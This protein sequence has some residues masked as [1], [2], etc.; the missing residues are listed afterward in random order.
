MF[1]WLQNWRK[2]AA[3]KEQE[4]ITVYLDGGMSGREAT[5]FESRLRADAALQAEIEAQ[6]TVKML[7]ARAPKLRAPRNFVLDPAVYGRQK[8]VPLSW[9]AMIYPQLRTATL[10]ASLLFAVTL[11]LTLFNGNGDRVQMSQDVAMAPEAPAMTAEAPLAE[12]E[13]ALEQSQDSESIATFAIEAES[14]AVILEEESAADE[15]ASP[16]L[17]AEYSAPAA[18]SS[19]DMAVTNGA[20]D[21]SEDVAEGEAEL[22]APRATAE[23]SSRVLDNATSET[24]MTAIPLATMTKAAPETAAQSQEAVAIAPEDQSATKEGEELVDQNAGVGQKISGWLSALF[25]LIALGLLA[26]TF[27]AKRQLN[28]L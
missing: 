10:V 23:A 14:S 24:E 16:T 6:R 20:D 25:G 11:S 17:T 13:P 3:E 18:A 7:L 21:G 12:A 22:V 19:G 27:W 4:A 2:S 8:P 26:I 5:D 15:M 1:D 9:G 28:T